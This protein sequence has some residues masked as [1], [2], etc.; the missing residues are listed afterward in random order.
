MTF[1]EIPGYKILLAIGMVAL[2]GFGAFQ[3]IGMHKTPFEKATGYKDYDALIASKIA[4]EE[5]VAQSISDLGGPGDDWSKARKGD[6]RAQYRLGNVYRDGNRSEAQNFVE[7]MKW[8]RMAADQKY[9]PAEYEVGRMYANGMGMPEN[10]KEAARWYRMAADGGYKWAQIHLGEI[11]MHF[12]AEQFGVQ[13]D[14]VEADFWLTL[15]TASEDFHSDFIRDR[16]DA[17]SNL[18]PAEIESVKRRVNEW[19]ATH[20]VPPQ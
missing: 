7:A 14:F 11:Y 12:L 4:Y 3:L 18:K 5:Q 1:R 17:E 19:H 15:G 9:A 6:A 13:R 2:F 20:P 8:Y 16:D 10:E